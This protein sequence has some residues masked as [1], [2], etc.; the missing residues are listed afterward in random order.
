[1]PKVLACIVAAFGMQAAPYVAL[2]QTEIEE[3]TVIEKRRPRHAAQPAV[4]IDSET[5][6]E[7]TPTAL[8]DIFRRVQSVGI[9]TNSRG[10]AVLRLAR[11]RGAPDRHLPR[12]R[13]AQ[14]AL[15]RTRGPERATGRHRRTRA[16]HGERGA[17][18]VRNEHGARG[19][20]DPYAILPSNPGCR[21]SR[22]R[23]G[24]RN[25]ARSA[26]SAESTTGPREL[27]ARRE[28]SDARRRGCREPFR[29]SIRPGE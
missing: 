19:G 20:R 24:A 13:A 18:R 29:D 14:R 1:M 10:E 7:I 3:V 5:I 11:L 4:V 15:G 21:A 25:P 6:R 2:A 9:R 26:P 12:R 28:L 27:A 17:Y 23:P 8:T 22:P 16:G